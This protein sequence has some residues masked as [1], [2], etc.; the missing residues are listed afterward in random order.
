[1]DKFIHNCVDS[2]VLQLPYT[3][4]Y[5][6]RRLHK[7]TVVK[8]SDNLQ[9]VGCRERDRRA[10]IGTDVLYTSFAAVADYWTVCIL[11]DL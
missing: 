5:F 10:A 9:Q 1:V 8:I 7:S 2:I 4:I 11:I 6:A 3:D